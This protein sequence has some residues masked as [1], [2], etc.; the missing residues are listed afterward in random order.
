MLEH[1]KAIVYGGGGAI[2]AEIARVFAA[3]GARVY[4]AGR[5]GSALSAVAAQ[6][7]ALGREPAETSVV[8]VLDEVSVNAFAAQV[9]AVDICVNAVG[10]DGGAQGM[11]LIEMSADTVVGPIADA[12][13]SAYNTAK[14]AA[15]HMR[16][17][18]IIMLSTPMARMP[19]A[20]TGPFGSA[21]AA[22]ETL[23]RQLAAELGP[24]GTRVVCLRLTG[25]PE[26]ALRLGSQTERV[27][28]DAAARLGM[29]FEEVAEAAGAGSPLGRPL[30]VARVAEVAAFV[31]SDQA[32][33]LTG[34]VLNVSAGAVVD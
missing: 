3:Q 34:T 25:I 1:K 20:M 24:R 33:A 15:V 22:V 26:T 30:T 17:G 16:D 7:G 13:R 10:L 9:G 31:A 32:G 12:A 19:V 29:S 21:S 4:L 8:D 27:W 2:G 28:R 14:A 11:P 6:I 23:A 5:T 18:V